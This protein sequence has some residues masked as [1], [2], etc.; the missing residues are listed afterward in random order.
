MVKPSEKKLTRASHM[1]LTM[2]PEHFMNPMFVYCDALY[3]SLFQT[4]KS[5]CIHKR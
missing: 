3:I 4:N 1:I 5:I 2:V